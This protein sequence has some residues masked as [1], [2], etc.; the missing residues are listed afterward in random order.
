M[1]MPVLQDGAAAPAAPERY[2]ALHPPTHPREPRLIRVA[3]VCL[4]LMGR[5]RP[6]IVPVG[7]E[8]DA[9]ELEGGG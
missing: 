7:D 8:L 9:G 3:W 1:Q 5:L 2:S 6:E 4:L